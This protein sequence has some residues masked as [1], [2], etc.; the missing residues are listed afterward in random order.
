MS[1]VETSDTISGDSPK[2][3]PRMLSAMVLFALEHAIGA[4][5]TENTPDIEALPAGVKETVS[6][7]GKNPSAPM[8][9]EHVVQS[10]YISELIDIIK[11]GW[12]ESGKSGVDSRRRLLKVHWVA[13]IWLGRLNEAITACAGW[14]DGG[15]LRPTLA[16]IFVSAKKRI[17]EHCGVQ[18]ERELLI[19]ETLE[20]LGFV[21]RSDG[22][23]GFVAHETLNIL[24]QITRIAEH[25]AISPSC[26]SCRVPVYKCSFE[27]SL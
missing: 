10:T 1:L 2:P 24:E 12:A 16:C 18:S 26:A 13:A 20:A 5:V 7:R 14:K 15:E 6:Q 21:L 27:L 22:Y 19:R 25:P 3:N 8:T 11:D 9:V 17:L 23:I 4:Y